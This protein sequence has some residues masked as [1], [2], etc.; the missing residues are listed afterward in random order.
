MRVDQD[1]NVSSQSGMM[2]SRDFSI[3]LDG[4]MFNNLINGM[5]SDKIA[6]PIREISTNARDGH[7]AVGLLDTPF[8]VHLPSKMTPLFSVRDFGCSLTHDEVMDMYS[9]LGKSTKRDTDEMTGCLGLGSKSPFAYTSTF[10]VT[11]WKDNEMRVYSAYIS[12]G[13]QPTIALVSRERSNEPTGVLVSIAVKSGDVEGFNRTANDVFMGFSPKPNVTNSNGAYRTE[14][15]IIRYEG[16]GWKIFEDTE[17]Y[18]ENKSFAIQGSVAYPIKSSNSDLRNALDKGTRS[19][20]SG[21]F[22][23]NGTIESKIL[24][25]CSM[26]IDFDIG[27]L[28]T[29]TSREDLAYDPKTCKSIVDRIGEIGKELKEQIGKKYK[30]AGT[31]IEARLMLSKD[32]AGHG[33]RRTL[34]GLGIDLE[35]MKWSDGTVIQAETY[36]YTSGS[37]LINKSKSVSYNHTFS[38]NELLTGA[39]IVDVALLDSYKFKNKKGTMKSV[40]KFNSLLTPRNADRVN[41]GSFNDFYTN[42]TVI[43]QCMDVVNKSDNNKM[44]N[45]WFNDAKSETLWIRVRNKLAATK[46]I[47]VLTINPDNVFYLNDYDDL[48]MPAAPKG[49]ANV[50]A[51]KTKETFRVIRPS[52]WGNSHDNRF[53]DVSAT[54]TDK[55]IVFY[56][57]GQDFFMSEDDMNSN[58]GGITAKCAQEKLYRWYDNLNIINQNA[59]ALILNSKNIKLKKTQPI[60]TDVKDWLKAETL[61][62]VPDLDATLLAMQNDRLVN[63]DIVFFSTMGEQSAG[64]LPKTI[65]RMINKRDEVM[66]NRNPEAAKLMET[67]KSVFPSEYLKAVNKLEADPKLNLNVKGYLAN[68]LILNTLIIAAQDKYGYN[69]QDTK[70]VKQALTQYLTL[71]KRND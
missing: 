37:K 25:Y 54:S 70:L 59:C 15:R 11:C 43:F 5:Y 52:R 2:E 20:Q 40:F 27:K 23:N 31:L 66:K 41:G 3:N 32:M 50:V 6:A 36:I 55:R 39:D 4:M 33:L 26:V 19:T 60:F 42:K 56:Q 48:K 63:D 58:T 17:R 68:D 67:Y 29:T 53:E 9:V 7:A 14:E 57:K 45:F 34:D 22:G 1:T 10:N 64:I 49:V 62:A 21:Y 13:G 61:K 35:K 24:Q 28:N 8:D 65:R 44:R 51:A 47:E 12:T 16:K 46:V 71:L 18:G 69:R 30:E 38:H